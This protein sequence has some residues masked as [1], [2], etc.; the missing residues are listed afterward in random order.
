LATIER[1]ID[2]NEFSVGCWDFTIW[3]KESFTWQRI[4][5][6]CDIYGDFLRDGNFA[7]NQQFQM[8]ALLET[9]QVPSNQASIWI[10]GPPTQ[11]LFIWSWSMR[12]YWHES[13]Q[14]ENNNGIRNWSSKFTLFTVRAFP[15]WRLFLLRNS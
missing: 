7:F 6:L 2:K 8:I 10:F 13:R 4:A 11:G 15:L 5:T 1:Q 9:A 12:K 3:K 14:F